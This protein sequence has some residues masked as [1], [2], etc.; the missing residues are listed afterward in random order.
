MQDVKY[1]KYIKSP[2]QGFKN[3]S[4]SVISWGQSKYLNT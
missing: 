1:T 2:G 4:R 3:R